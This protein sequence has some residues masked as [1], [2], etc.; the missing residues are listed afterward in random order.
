MSIMLRI[1]LL[2][3]SILTMVYIISR[4]RKS[5]MKIETSLFWIFFSLLCVIFAAFPGIAGFFSGVIG[6]NSPVNFLFLFF[7]FLLLIKE[8]SMSIKISRLEHS[9]NELA[10]KTAIDAAVYDMQIRNDIDK[11]YYNSERDV[12]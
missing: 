4:I 10:Q 12:S 6:I 5:K 3:V 8:F 9:L 1:V 2:I 11:T 7:I